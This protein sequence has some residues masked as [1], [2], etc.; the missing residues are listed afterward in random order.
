[1]PAETLAKK[2]ARVGSS[3]RGHQLYRTQLQVRGI[4]QTQVDYQALISGKINR[5]LGIE[6][7]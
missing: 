3:F 5:I 2:H 7:G 4:R 6:N 1:M